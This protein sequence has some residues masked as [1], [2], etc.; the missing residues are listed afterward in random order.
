MELNKAGAL[1]VVSKRRSFVRIST[2]V[3]C[4]KCIRLMTTRDNADFACLS[5]SQMRYLPI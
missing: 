1:R 4:I 2:K 3:N 5:P